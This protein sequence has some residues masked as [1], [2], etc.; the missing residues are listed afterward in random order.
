M[1]KNGNSRKNVQKTFEQRV[2]MK[3]AKEIIQ[4]FFQL[5][6]EKEY[7]AL[8]EMMHD[9]LRW[10]IIG[11]IKTS[12]EKDK[13]LM[14]LGF[15]FLKRIFQNFKFILHDFTIEDNR[16]AVTAESEA[17]HKTGFKYNNHYHFLFFLEGEKIKS[18]KEY[19]DTK[20]AS[21]IESL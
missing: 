16:V 11:D 17:I 9:D 19:F 21:V 10:W 5:L 14:L 3:N 4:K 8:E 2:S 7:G 6:N 18:V 20:L 15:K 1:E 13:R 12:G